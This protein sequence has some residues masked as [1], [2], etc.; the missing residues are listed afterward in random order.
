V[1]KEN[2]TRAEASEEQEASMTEK[3]EKRSFL[4]W[5][6]KL[7]GCEGEGWGRDAS[8]YDASFV[9]QTLDKARNFIGPGRYFDIRIDGW[10][11][12]DETPALNIANHSG[13]MLTLDAWGWVTA[14][15]ERLSTDRALHMLAHEAVFALPS[16]A[17]RLS[18]LGALRADF[19]TGLS[20]LRDQQRD[21]LLFPGG[22]LDTFRPYKDRY[23]VNFAGRKGYIRL[24]L[25]AGRPIRP[26]AH[27]GAHETLIVLSSGKKIAEALGLRKHFRAQ[28][29]PIYLCFPW[30]LSLIPLPHLPPPTQLRYKIGGLIEMPRK[31]W[32]EH[33]PAELVEQLD[34]HVREEMQKLLDQLQAEEPEARPLRRLASRVFNK[35][36]QLAHTFLP[37][38]PSSLHVI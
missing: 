21:L 24:A 30:G 13:G 18:R 31:T 29:Y 38:D 33:P 3:R 2:D 17:S 14:W 6:E 36:A 32:R 8:H 26:I 28:I 35:A 22:D 37:Q 4:S 1:L 27:A 25:E 5:C 7:T 15:Y 23:K 10:E 34:R 9:R 11:H 16:L 20:I 12:I 19:A